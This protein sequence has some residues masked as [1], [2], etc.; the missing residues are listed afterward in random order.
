MTK[1]TILVNINRCTGCWTCSTA[2]KMDHE[3][4]PEEFRSYIRTLGGNQLD[5]PAGT[6]PDLRMG[7]M[8]MYTDKCTL[9]GDK[10]ALGEEPVCV[11][12]CPTKALTF[13][14]LDDPQSAVSQRAEDLKGKGFRM[15]ELP[16][17]ENTRS[18]IVYIEK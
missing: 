7:W 17:W 15:F 16:K 4:A 18:N 12:H 11:H 3:L 13:G 8:P 9:C 14:D 10:I 5:E 1:P 6:Y 2:C